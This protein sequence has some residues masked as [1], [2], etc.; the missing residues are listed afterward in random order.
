MDQEPS[1]GISGSRKL[2]G[3]VL[4]SGEEADKKISALSGGECGRLVL[5]RI[6]KQK[7]NILI[8]DEPTNHLD[9]E[10]V[11]ALAQALQEYEGTLIVVSHNRFLVRAVADRLI[12]IKP[13][14]IEEFMGG[15][16]EY[17]QK[18]KEDY[19]KANRKSVSNKQVSK[20]KSGL[21]YEE[22]KRI[23][24]ELK[25]FLDWFQSL[26]LNIRSLKN[27]MMKTWL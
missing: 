15:Y 5:A 10:T 11:E 12:L 21:S 17:L 19:L 1:L 13:D 27:L 23:K 8:M 7:Q 20:A 6:M 3:L 9:L 2:L 18:G 14:G 24:S 16:E 4:F 22:Q 25:K 26:S